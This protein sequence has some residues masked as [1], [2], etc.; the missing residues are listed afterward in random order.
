MATTSSPPST[1]LAISS[2]ELDALLSSTDAFPLDP[3]VEFDSLALD[4]VLQTRQDETQDITKELDSILVSLGTPPSPPASPLLP[5]DPSPPETS[6][7]TIL[8]PSIPCNAVTSVLN[9]SPE[10]KSRDDARAEGAEDGTQETGDAKRPE[11]QTWEDDSKSEDTLSWEDDEVLLKRCACRSEV[12]KRRHRDELKATQRSEESGAA[13]S[14]TPLSSAQKERARSRRE[15]AVTRM[16]A[17]VY[18]RELETVVRGVPALHREIA[19]LR[20]ALIS[21]DRHGR[22]AANVG[23]SI[24]EPPSPCHHAAPLTKASPLQSG[25]PGVATRLVGSLQK[26]GIESDMPRHIEF[27]SNDG[28]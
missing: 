21:D 6:A 26:L 3:S 22:N 11:A 8:A 15:S 14:G 5:T 28:V 13:A 19:V 12:A 17:V 23:K 2:A 9:G 27:P 7:A 20:R 1:P 18:V 24:D 4:E 25:S 16:R 10:A